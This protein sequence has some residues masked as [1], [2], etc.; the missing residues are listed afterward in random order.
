MLIQD[1]LT[2]YLH[3][4]PDHLYGS[5]YGGYGQ[6]YGPQYGEYPQGYGYSPQPVAGQVVYDGL[7][8]P[9]GMLPL[10][11]ALAPLAAKVL[12]KIVDKVLPGIAQK[13]PLIGQLLPAISSLFSGMPPGLAQAEM[14]PQAAVMVDPQVAPPGAAVT[15]LPPAPAQPAALPAPTLMPMQVA[16]QAMMVQTMMRAPRRR[17]GRHLRVIRRLIPV[18]APQAQPLVAAPIREAGNAEPPGGV[19]GWGYHG[20]FNGYG[21]W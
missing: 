11:T 12:P 7:G 15:A 8:N 21:R 18:P 13:S 2:G 19:Q 9:V 6:P 17:R 4:V 20:G 3:D 5:Y 16:P 14:D 1:S 10:L